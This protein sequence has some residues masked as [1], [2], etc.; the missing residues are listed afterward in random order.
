M[1]NITLNTALILSICTVLALTVK[2]QAKENNCN[3]LTKE[4]AQLEKDL[5]QKN[6]LLAKQK[7]ELEKLPAE[8][9]SAKMKITAD[10]IVTAAE[11]ES[12]QNWIEVKKKERLKN[13]R[14]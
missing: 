3:A 7:Q 8:S 5:I 12:T 4:I 1:K 11:S 2:A 9:A 10:S 14:K 6:K 13:C